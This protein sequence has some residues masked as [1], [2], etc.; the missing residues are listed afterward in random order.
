MNIFPNQEKMLKNLLSPMNA[1]L[2]HMIKLMI[3]NPYM[4]ASVEFM[5][6]YFYIQLGNLLM[7]RKY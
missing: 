5:K 7:Y 2:L 1:E 6:L 4:K 3:K